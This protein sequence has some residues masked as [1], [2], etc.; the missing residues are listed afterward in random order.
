M[1]YYFFTGD[2][3]NGEL[4]LAALPNRQKE[5]KESIEQAITYAKALKCKRCVPI[6]P[7]VQVFFLSTRPN[8]IVDFV[9]AS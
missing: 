2:R 8:L 5:F 7:Y 4:G 6:S 1:I 3:K 9:K